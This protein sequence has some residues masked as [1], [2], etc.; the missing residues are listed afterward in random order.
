[1]K[2]G[3]KARK[4]Y[5]SEIARRL[6]AI[7]VRWPDDLELFATGQSIIL[8]KPSS[9]RVLYDIVGIDCDGGDP[10]VIV[11]DNGIEWMEPR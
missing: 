10:D 11:D 8:W 3:H 6:E 4:L 7:A 9:G 1:M 5:P 2:T